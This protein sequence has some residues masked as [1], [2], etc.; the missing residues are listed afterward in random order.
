MQEPYARDNHH[1]GVQAALHLCPL[2]SQFLQLIWAKLRILP[3]LEVP[4]Y[5]EIQYTYLC[6]ED[7]RGRRPS[8]NSLDSTARTE[9]E[10]SPGSVLAQ[11]TCSFTAGGYPRKTLQVSPRANTAKF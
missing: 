2:I 3:I 4:R 6:P 7:W 9:A 1:N 11:A 5:L 8:P 10:E